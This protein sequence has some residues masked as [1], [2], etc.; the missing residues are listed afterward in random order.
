MLKWGFLVLNAFSVPSRWLTDVRFGFHWILKDPYQWT[1]V[2]GVRRKRGRNGG[3]TVVVIQLGLRGYKSC[4]DHLYLTALSK[5]IPGVLRWRKLGTYRLWRVQLFTAFDSHNIT[6]SNK[7]VMS[8][9]IE[10]RVKGILKINSIIITRT[11]STGKRPSFSDNFAS[12][13]AHY[14]SFDEK[15]E[16]HKS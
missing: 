7:L 3:G 6:S 2:A 4:S 8:L 11:P 12:T 16:L 13:R 5:K 14:F 9:F 1:C 15:L 10:N